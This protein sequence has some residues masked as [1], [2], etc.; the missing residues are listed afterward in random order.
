M[1]ATPGRARLVELAVTDLG[2]IDHLGLVLG[3]GMTAITGETGAGKT[4]VVGAIELLLG[5]RADAAVVRPGASEAVVEGRFEVDDRELVLTRVVPAEGRSRAYVD[6]RMATAASLAEATADLVDLHGQHAHQSLLSISV[7][8]RA[9]D[10]FG[11]IDLRAL[12]EARQEVRRLRDELGRLG[13][14][15]GARAREIDLLRHQIGEIERAA[16]DDPNEDDALDAAETLLADAAAH[17][18][19]AARTADLLSADGGAAD[20]VAQALAAMADRSPFVA[21]RDRLHGLLAEVTDL[22]AEVRGLAESIDEDPAELAR[23]R[24]RR[25]LLVEL[26]R[27]YGTAPH[28]LRPDEAGSGT[29]ADVVAFVAGARDRLAELLGHEE[30]AAALE[31][32]L[33]DAGSR[34]QEIAALVGRARRA[35]APRL[36]T[37]VE[38]HLAELAMPK[39]RFAVEVGRHDPGDPVGFTLA[40]NPG[41]PAGPLAKVASG[42]ELART[43]LALRLVV[44][45]APPIL[46]FDEVDAGIG[47]DAAVAVGRALGRLGAAHQ[48]LVVTHL[49]QVA[50][51][52]HHQVRLVKDGDRSVSAVRAE[53]LAGDDRVEE[54]ARMLAGGAGGSSMLVAARELL[55][56]VTPRS[57]R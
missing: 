47:G 21:P 23:L 49:P 53:V 7:Q 57:V 9:L 8:G 26:R 17:R 48:V 45:G 24:E 1:T 15:A 11:G 37:A 27:K 34:E 42:G 44:A 4:M 10:D 30:R 38:A 33:A 29:L 36:A 16:V 43:M 28:P 56:T 35:A 18:E 51:F 39:A 12:R 40:A 54:I 19:A 46:V 52:A 22:A 50:A 41:L 32:A 14:D 13:G 25:H 2:I 20:L 55:D 3:P 5:A 31:Q 6:G